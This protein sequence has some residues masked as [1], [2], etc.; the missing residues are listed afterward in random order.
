MTDEFNLEDELHRKV[1]EA[2]LWL[3]NEYKRQAITL[4]AYH[5]ALTTFDMMTLGLVPIEWNDWAAEERKI[6]NAK[7]SDK[8]VLSRSGISA[9]VGVAIICLELN[10]VKG[11]INVV[12]I[13]NLGTQTKVMTF[14][15]ETDPIKAAGLKYPDVIKGIQAKGY[16]VIM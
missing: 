10:R 16:K 15:T 11:E 6:G 14:E 5:T 8:T 13:T 7:I 4:E 2:L 12:H 3:T 9:G 1:G